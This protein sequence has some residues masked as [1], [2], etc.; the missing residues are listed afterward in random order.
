M[1]SKKLSKYITSFDYND[2]TLIVLPETSGGISI[3]S[4]P[5][6]IGVLVAMASPIFTLTTGIIKKLL[7][8]TRNKKKNIIKL[9]CLLKVK[10]KL[11]LN[12]N[13]SSII[14]S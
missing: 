12:S 13:F 4:F 2:K 3:I 9:L 10:I 14:R 1:A 7:E 5:S 11:H 6:I 8:I